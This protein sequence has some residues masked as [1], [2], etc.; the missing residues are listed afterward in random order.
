MSN[1]SGM[2]L[3][4]SLL[5]V[6]LLLGG[7]VGHLVYPREVTKETIKEVPIDK[8]VEVE[9]IVEKSIN[10]KQLVVDALVSEIAKDKDLRMCREDKFNAEDISV[11]KISDGFLVTEDINGDLSISNV[12]VKLLYSDDD[13]NCYNTLICELNTDNELKYL[14][15]E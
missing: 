6:G 2:G 14:I 12:E 13:G 7:I 11:R 1:N 3:A 9:K 4:I 15:V 5:I 10:Y 8:I